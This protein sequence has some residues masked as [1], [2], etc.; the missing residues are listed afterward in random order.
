M[1]RIDQFEIYQLGS[2]VHPL[3]TFRSP[4]PDATEV[5]VA[6]LQA[7]ARLEPLLAAESP[8]PLGITRSAV[9]ALVSEVVAIIEN[10]F[11][12][13]DGSPKFPETGATMPGWRLFDLSTAAREFEAVFKAEMRTASTY[14]VPKRAAFDT[15]TMVDGAQDLIPADLRRH[16]G[17]KAETE[18]RSG[19]K[20]YAFGLFTAAGYHICRAVESAL[21][22]YHDAFCG[23]ASKRMT[24]N[25]YIDALEKFVGAEGTPEPEAR[26]LHNL[27]QVK[28]NSRNPLMHPRAVLEETDAYI[29]INECVASMTCM[30][31]EIDAMQASMQPSLL[32]A[33]GQPGAGIAALVQGGGGQTP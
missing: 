21:G 4:N 1:E 13:P 3:L 2:A 27:K 18:L 9:E 17:D 15:A 33:A 14:S 25:D 32:P 20:A 30:V 7:R 31:R 16:L 24:M 23:P 28:D 22:K 26:T 12:E 6:L 29:L 19:G 8:I 5:L 11:Q 10:A